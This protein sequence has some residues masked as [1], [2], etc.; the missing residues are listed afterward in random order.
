MT[1][2]VSQFRALGEKLIAA[3]GLLNSSDREVQRKGARDGAT[4]LRV[5]MR[6]LQFLAAQ[7]PGNLH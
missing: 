1:M 4:A 7:S 3:G 5:L 6:E 2:T